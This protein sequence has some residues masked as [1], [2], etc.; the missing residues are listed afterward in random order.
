MI[1]YLRGSKLIRSAGVYTAANLANAA[2]PFLMLPVLTRVLPPSGYGVIAMYGAVLGIMSAFT[3]LSAD[4]AVSVRYVDREGTDFPR[5]VGS[6]LYLL[7]GSTLAT[8]LVVSLLGAP[9][10]RFTSI[11]V[12]WLL[13]A[14]PTS[15]CTFLC[16]VRLGIWIMSHRSVAYGSFQVLQS[17][18][19]MGLSLL[20]VLW[21]R[22]GYQGRLWGQSAA[23]GLFATLALVSL[24]RGKLASFSP[25]REYLRDALAFGVP[26]VPHVIGIC[27]IGLADRF[28][29]N[30]KLG[31]TEAG[32]YLVAVQ[33]GMGLSVLSDAF[34]KAFVPWLYNQLKL[35]SA[36]ARC[37]IIRGTWAYFAGALGIAG[38]V[39]ALSY[40]IV[41]FVAGPKYLGAAGALAWQALGQ[42]F[43]GMYLMVTNYI[44]YARRT[45]PL[46]LIT[47]ISGGLSLSLTWLLVPLLGISGAGLSFALSM[48]VRF[49]L[50]WTLAQRVCPMPW[51]SFRA[52]SAAKVLD[53]P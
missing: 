13:M 29:I 18:L 24:V 15:A 21:F 4:G 45:R 37:Q 25:C 10:S 28:I 11:P 30:Q 46:A 34:N 48:C 35:D 51:L 38:L 27:L 49:L 43:L 17:A 9:L 40:W 6:C 52:P 16:N 14:V 19:N 47:F 23:L 53:T 36:E 3:G 12:F 22:Q 2:I 42:A 33:L 31:L 50:T 44:F 41:L 8:L 20:F 5:Y 39:A 26:L 7:L 1:N 32:I